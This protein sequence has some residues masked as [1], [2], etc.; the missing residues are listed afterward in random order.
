MS[1][2]FHITSGDIAGENLAKAGLPGEI[3]VWHDILYDGPRQ[4]GWPSENILKARSLF[5]EEFTAGGLDRDYILKTLHNQYQKLAEA[6][7]HGKIMLWFDACLFDQSMLSHLLACLALK[8]IQK[9]ELLCINSFPG[10][11]PFHGLGQLQ[12]EQFAS[13]YNKRQPIAN[14]QFRFAAIV[15]KAFATQDTALLTKLSQMVN[16]PLPWTPA[17]VTRWLQE[18]PDSI[19][20][21]GRLESLALEAIQNGCETPDKIF[22][23]VSTAD[24]PPH[25]WGDTTLWTKI[26]GLADRDPPLIGIEGPTKK[27]PQWE[28]QIS[29]KEFKIK[30]LPNHSFHR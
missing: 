19:T 27:L 14:E 3:F 25:F 30:L 12:P 22:Q 26:N 10:I 4:P 9:A 17:A 11:E 7:S 5:L 8:G 13:L 20:G 1:K 28:S 16:P 21:L 18:Q 15:D 23:S 2:V 6:G 24:I 29:L